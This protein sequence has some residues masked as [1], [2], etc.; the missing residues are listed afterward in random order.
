MYRLMIIL[1]LIKQ[2]L[3]EYMFIVRGLNYN[4]LT[5]CL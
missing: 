1:R 2:V 4:W 5:F 3:A